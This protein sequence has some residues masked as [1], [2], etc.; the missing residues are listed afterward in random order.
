MAEP[1]KPRPPMPRGTPDAPPRPRRRPPEKPTAPP[2]PESRFGWKARV[3]AAFLAL[4]GVTGL[5][6]WLHD[7]VS[8]E[9][10]A[11]T[12][13]DHPDNDSAASGGSEPPPWTDAED[14]GLEGE[15]A[16]RAAEHA[17]FKRKIADAIA[18]VLP[19][20]YGLYWVTAE[21]GQ[22]LYDE[23]LTLTG[24]DG[25]PLGQ[26]YP[27][28]FDGVLSFTVDDDLSEFVE[29]ITGSP[30]GRVDFSDPA[31]TVTLLD[32]VAELESAR[33]AFLDHQHSWPAE[34]R[35]EEYRATEQSIKDDIRTA[36]EQSTVT[37]VETQRERAEAMEQALL[38]MQEELED[39]DTGF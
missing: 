39:E 7:R 21:S 13:P 16:E 38:E 30:M 9:P 34:D 36:L 1:I 15:D 35:D 3:L 8:S 37:T 23:F 25:S 26:I 19:N 31:D 29:F 12:A 11:P 24:P 28:E 4:G 27:S 2:P 14:T 10:P 6:T 22:R 32:E 18:E 33:Q 20:E 17:E 5:I